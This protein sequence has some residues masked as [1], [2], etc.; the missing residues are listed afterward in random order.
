M[1]LWVP[2]SLNLHEKWI[3][4]WKKNAVVVARLVGLK[5][6]GPAFPKNIKTISLFPLAKKNN[7]FLVKNGFGIIVKR[8]VKFEMPP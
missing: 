5:K 2:L 6:M 7:V 3:A 1:N 8:A 4:L